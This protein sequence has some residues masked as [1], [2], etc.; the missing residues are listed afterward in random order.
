MKELKTMSNNKK[1]NDF[2]FIVGR[3]QSRCSNIW[4][5]RVRKN[6]VYVISKSF[7]NDYKSK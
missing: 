1:K 4:G 7:G 6:D 3:G 5:I 2:K